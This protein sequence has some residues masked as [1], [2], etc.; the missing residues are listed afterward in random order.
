MLCDSLSETQTIV[1]AN[2]VHDII[3]H[4]S[5]HSDWSNSFGG[6]VPVWLLTGVGLP[7]SIYC[8]EKGSRMRMCGW[9]TKPIFFSQILVLHKNRETISSNLMAMYHSDSLHS[10]QK[11]QLWE[12]KNRYYCPFESNY[13]S[14]R[15]QQMDCCYLESGGWLF[16]VQSWAIQ[17][18]IP[19]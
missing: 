2:A 17:A 4:Q 16:A 13:N 19:Q 11:T 14:D 6:H 15:A 8:V 18:V 3:A 7:Q 1:F 5:F 9:D 12:M 10:F